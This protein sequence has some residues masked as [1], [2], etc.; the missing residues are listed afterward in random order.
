[1]NEKLSKIIEVTKLEIS[2]ELYLSVIFEISR[3]FDKQ[4][5]SVYKDA[6]KQYGVVFDSITRKELRKHYY[7]G[8]VA[9]FKESI[10]QIPT[11]SYNED[12]I[13][14]VCS[15]FLSRLEIYDSNKIIQSMKQRVDELKNGNRR[16]SNMRKWLSWHKTKKKE[17]S[18]TS[19]QINQDFF[20]KENYNEHIIENFILGTYEQLENYR[21]L[22]IVINGEIFNQN[23]EAITWNLLYKAVIFAENFIQYREKFSPFKKEKKIAEMQSFLKTKDINIDSEVESFYSSISTG[24]K[25]EDCY[26][27]DDQSVKMILLKKIELDSTNIPCPACNTTEQRG[28]SYSKLFLRSWECS[29]PSCPERSK[30]GRGKRFD[31]YSAYRYFKLLERKTEN[32]IDEEFYK[33]WRRDIFNHSLNYTEML[34]REYSWNQEDILLFGFNKQEI[35]Y[36]RKIHYDYTTCELNRDYA[37]CYEELPIVKLFESLAT[38]FSRT[39]TRQKKLCKPLEIING[40]S[41][42]VLNKLALNQIGAAIT[43]PPYYNA[44]EYSQWP[45]LLLYLIDMMENARAVYDVLSEESYYLYNIGDVVNEDNVYVNS[46]MSNRRQALGFLSCMIFEIVGFKLVGNM[47]WDKGEVQSK[48]N[49]TVNMY[50]GY[51]KCVNCYEHVLMFKK[52]SFDELHNEVHQ[53]TPVI[54]INSKGENTYKHTAPYPPE[55]VELI[56]PF[57]K[58]NQYLLDPFLGSG[59]TVKWCKDNFLQGVGIEMNE[60]YYNLCCEKVFKNSEEEI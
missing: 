31:E 2:N 30:S 38:Q 26:I 21:H 53:I 22:A 42:E 58:E 46:H 36:S 40:N 35:N 45:T 10:Y 34:I 15:D 48:R 47:I 60:D 32:E 44:R 50:S 28:N 37:H 24:F 33:S 12:D 25:F 9:T 23:G 6:Q 7:Y 14:N 52:G 4:L 51:I 1:M 20:E 11:I 56:R 3:Y 13:E 43:S 59:T 57:I 49:S 27:S 29:N 19:I 16:E 54:K 5:T 41:T 8:D 18:F 39:T 55:I 17:Y